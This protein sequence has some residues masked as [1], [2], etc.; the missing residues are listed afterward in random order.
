MKSLEDIVRS[1][2]RGSRSHRKQN[3]T[4]PS[5]SARSQTPQSGSSET[6][7]LNHLES[8]FREGSS[9]QT[10]SITH[11]REF[12]KCLEPNIPEALWDS[13]REET[14]LLARLFMESQYYT[15]GHGLKPRRRYGRAFRE[16]VETLLQKGADPNMTIKV[17]EASWKVVQRVSRHFPGMNRLSY[18]F[19]TTPFLESIAL[20]DTEMMV[21]FLRHGVNALDL[22]RHFKIVKLRNGISDFAGLLSISHR[23]QSVRDFVTNVDIFQDKSLKTWLM[24][25][26]QWTLRII[27]KD[28]DITYDGINIF[29]PILK[30]KINEKNPSKP[31]S[32][33]VWSHSCEPLT[34]A[35]CPHVRDKIFDL[36]QGISEPSRALTSTMCSMCQ[37]VVGNRPHITAYPMPRP[38]VSLSL[39][40]IL[41]TQRWELLSRFNDT[42][43]RHAVRSVPCM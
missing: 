38:K 43:R 14:Y 19:L 13:G 20:G 27:H 34:T 15:R 4:H 2:Y 10:G 8:G 23:F 37:L 36:T 26:I 39:Q 30:L 29:S 31:L 32:G 24:E 11:P 12:L 3:P 33:T 41:E 40:H 18:P 16:Q 7:S 22:T 5:E 9:E 35:E 42:E 17:Y 1:K 25:D 21:L 28:L 6:R